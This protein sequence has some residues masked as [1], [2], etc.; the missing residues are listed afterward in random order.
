[1]DWQLVAA[2]AGL[3]LLAGQRVRFVPREPAL[4]DTP[5]T[6]RVTV[7]TLRALAV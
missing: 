7:T 1:M 4:R 3:A 2:L 5:L 6:L